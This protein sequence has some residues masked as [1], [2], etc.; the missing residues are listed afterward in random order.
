[1][2]ILSGLSHR[3]GVFTLLTAWL[4]AAQS[5]WAQ[6]GISL[7]M[8]SMYDS[9]IY[10]ESGDGLGND[11]PAEFYEGIENGDIV[12]PKDADQKKN[13]DIIGLASFGLSAA[14][15]LSEHIKSSFD[16]SIG[17]LLFSQ[18][19]Q[20]DRLIYDSFL[21]F[22]SEESLIPKPFQISLTSALTSSNQDIGV[23]EGTVARQSQS[24][25]GTLALKAQ[26]IELP[27]ELLFSAGYQLVRHDFIGET[28]FDRQDEDRA[29]E[30]EG[31][32]FFSNSLDMR[33]N[34]LLTPKL[35]AEL[36]SRGTLYTFT[37]VRS[38]T[39]ETQDASDMDRVDYGLSTGLDYE[40][41]ETTIASTRVGVTFS[42]RLSDQDTI[43][44]VET[45]PDG[46][47]RRTEVARDDTSSVFTFGA[48][49]VYAPF[50]ASS[51]SLNASQD[52]GTDIDGQRVTTRNAKL[53]LSQGLGERVLVG[54]WGRYT[55]YE[56]SDDL[57]DT[58][59]LYELGANLTVSITEWFSTSLAYSFIKQNTDESNA[60]T[61][62]FSVFRS[63]DYDT[64]RVMLSLNAGFAGTTK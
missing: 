46:S 48:G 7:E 57:Q 53:Q 40:L 5:S 37:E 4:F 42:T 55:N 17:T 19:N 25:D 1:M 22:V 50:E 27:G 3:I 11:L 58:K 45:A 33:L 10:L 39:V 32:D 26:G 12:I 51:I 15:P 52:L 20:E 43:T 64:H 54:G 62:Y 18:E 59:D 41:S 29:R 6:V 23:A 34:K 21:Q 35:K 24:H 44:V 14:L 28:T 13:D 49:L 9:N 56:Y 63:N 47:E 61:D 31:S 38:N 16:G 60:D 30:E 8:S 36:S 2:K